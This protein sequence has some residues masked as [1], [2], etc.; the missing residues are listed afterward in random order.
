MRIHLYTSNFKT[1]IKMKTFIKKIIVFIL[2]F[3]TSY[4][5]LIC[6][7]GD[8]APSFLKK[9][10]NYPLGSYGFMFSRM[11]EIKS[12]NNIE[13]LFLGSSHTYRGFDS[14]IFKKAGFVTFNMGSSNQSPFQTELLLKRYLKKVNPRIIIYE[15]SPDALSTDG[16]ESTL[17][18]FANDKNDLYSICL[19]FKQM[20]VKVCNT[21][22]YAIYKDVFSL[23]DEYNE[24]IIKE[25]D[26]YVKGGF[27]QKELKFFKNIN[28]C[29]NNIKINESQF[30]SFEK[31]INLIKSN[32]IN[33][34]LIQAPITKSLY[35]SRIDNKRFDEKIKKY[36]NY[37]NFNELFLF[38]DSLDFYDSEH[39][40]QKG[41]EKFNK[42]IIENII[43]K[44]N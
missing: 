9:N 20:N 16:V 39:L 31:I 10:L 29:R 43:K 35:M 30:K 24:S 15:I 23:N 13:I 27:V 4:V 26:L 40:N 41:V 3:I 11:K 8:F 7:W 44:N 42:L 32:K 1:E 6:M 37:F 36:G 28:Y 2:V 12:T 5:V 25:D 14:R 38:D 21:F 22:I 19:L 18:V 17:D 33:L 34:F